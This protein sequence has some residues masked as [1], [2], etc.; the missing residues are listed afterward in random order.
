MGIK[1]I[2]DGGDNMKFGDY[3]SIVSGK[4][5]IEDRYGKQNGKPEEDTFYVDGTDD[6]CESLF[7][8]RTEDSV[9]YRWARYMNTGDP[10]DTVL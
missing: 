7:V 8:E 10:R 9:I 4:P 3:V 6:I 1:Y 5:V 2:Q